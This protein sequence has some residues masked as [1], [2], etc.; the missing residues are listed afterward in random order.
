MADTVTQDEAAVR[1]VIDGVYAAWTANDPDAFVTEYAEDVT[2]AL[3]GTY[4]VGR[5][6]VRETM[7]AMFAGPLRGCRSRHEVLGVRVL[8]D[9]AIVTSRG[10]VVLADRAEPE[11]WTLETWVLAR[12]SSWSVRAYHNCPA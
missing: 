6:A 9:T 12:N 1:A 3:P 7:R 11:P 4:L 8:G 5:E 10:T 2:A